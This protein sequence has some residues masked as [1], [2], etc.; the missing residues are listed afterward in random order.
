MLVEWMLVASSGIELE[1]NQKHSPHQRLGLRQPVRGSQQA[2][3][4]VE[5]SGDIRMILAEALLEYRKHAPHQRLGFSVQ[6]ESFEK[7]CQFVGGI[8]HGSTCETRCTG[9]Q[10]Q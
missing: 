2:R 7:V 4:G 8:Q 5:G 3:E 6:R 10:F 9:P 1:E